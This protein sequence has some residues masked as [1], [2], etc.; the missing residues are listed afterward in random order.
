MCYTP[1][2]SIQ[3]FIINVISSFLLFFLT[4]SKTLKIIALYFFYLGWMQLFDYLLWVYPKPDPINAATTKLAMIISYLQPVVYLMIASIITNKMHMLSSIVV[5]IYTMYAIP[6]AVDIYDSVQFTSPKGTPP[7]Q[8]LVWDWLQWDG[9]ISTAYVMASLIITYQ[10]LQGSIRN[11]MLVFIIVSFLFA[12][13]KYSVN[14]SI[15]RF[16]CYFGSFVP[17]LTL[18]LTTLTA[19]N[20]RF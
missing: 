4:S 19:K 6:Y 1:E 7:R 15:G 9:P 14:Q 17:L 13:F 11:W 8:T 16:W 18:L 12:R 3:A 5:L 20:L 2:I 10:Y